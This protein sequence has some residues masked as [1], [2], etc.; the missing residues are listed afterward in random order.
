MPEPKNARR[1]IPYPE[2]ELD[3]YAVSS[4]YPLPDDPDFIMAAPVEVDESKKRAASEPGIMF[5][6][7]ISPAKRPTLQ[8][9]TSNIMGLVAA[10]AVA[11]LDSV[12]GPN[13]SASAVSH[14]QEAAN[15]AS[16]ASL[17]NEQSTQ[18][19][20]ANSD[21]M[22]V[23][24][25]PSNL[26]Q[27]PM[28]SYSADVLSQWQDVLNSNNQ[29]MAA[30]LLRAQLES[31]LQPQLQQQQLQQQLQQQQ[32]QQPEFASKSLTAEI[33]V[34]VLRARRGDV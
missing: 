27:F 1:L 23:A 15:G 29:L 26:S 5:Q 13:I 10:A 19:L 9:D 17:P 25:G 6:D 28:A 11:P 24:G 16:K 12:G 20:M 7:Q 21:L 31:V 3:F 4:K 8:S 34:A 18:A 33:L 2:N 14:L 22:A 32:Q 30:A